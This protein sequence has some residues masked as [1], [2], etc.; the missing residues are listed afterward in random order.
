[1]TSIDINQQP[2]ISDNKTVLTP[3]QI[4]YINDNILKPYVAKI[5]MRATTEGL[6]REIKSE[7]KKLNNDELPNI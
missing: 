5:N 1:M 3:E 4:T 6:P 2:N 7:L